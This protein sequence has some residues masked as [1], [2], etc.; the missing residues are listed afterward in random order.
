MSGSMS[1]FRRVAFVFMMLFSVAA[2]MPLAGSAQNGGNS[3]TAKECQKN[4][5]AE[6]VRLDDGSGFRNAGECSSYVATGGTLDRDDDG[7]GIPDGRDNCVDV[8]NPDQTDTDLDGL[9]DACDATPNGDDD[10]DGVDNLADNCLTD[11]NPDQ[12]DTDGDGIGDAC[13]LPAPPSI[14][15]TFQARSSGSFTCDPTVHLSNFAPPG[16]YFL[17]LERRANSGA[18]VNPGSSV[19][20]FVDGSGTGHVTIGNSINGSQ[21]RLSTDTVTSGWVMVSC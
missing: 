18:P 17:T 14:T 3:E 2:V 5:F 13:E 19:P 7:D 15:L 11:A 9:G 6:L 21:I 1:Q 8:A 10:A 4:G 12:A 20:L 16:Y